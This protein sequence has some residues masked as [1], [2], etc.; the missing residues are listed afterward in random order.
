LRPELDLEAQQKVQ[1]LTFGTV[2][3]ISF[4]NAFR[5]LMC[6]LTAINFQSFK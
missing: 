6:S 5:E 2:L 1:P 3:A 4:A